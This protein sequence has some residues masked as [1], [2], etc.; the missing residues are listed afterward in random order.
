[1]TVTQPPKVSAR[2][3]D[4]TTLRVGGPAESLTTV[5]STQDLLAAVRAADRAATPVL[6]LGGGSNV[7]VDD[8][9]F[10]GSVLK[11]ATRGHEGQ[12]ETETVL[13]RL[14]AGESWDQVVARTVEDGWSGL[15]ALSGIPGLVGATPIQN[16][17]AYGA[18]LDQALVEVDCLDRSTGDRVTLPAAACGLAY[19][20]SRFKADLG[21][22]V[23]LTITLRLARSRQSAPIRYPQLAHAL[24]VEI[25]AQ[26]DA[27]RVR[28][29]VLELRRG[30]GMVLDDNDHDTWSA[31]S[32]FTNPI[33]APGVADGLPA[34]APRFPQADGR[35]KTS[36]AW[37]IEHAGYDKGYGI[38]PAQLSRKH[39][40]AVT[41]RGGATAADLLRLAREVRAGVG[42]RFGIE[43]APEPVLIR[44]TL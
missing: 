34:S 31:G 30:K 40:L 29:A 38:P 23:I 6:V 15:E 22:Y 32:F 11:V 41:N 33:L 44:C 37:L 5:D 19:R 14:A 7:L 27:R 24:G 13:L 12:R 4:H 21:R 39:T 9:G 8:D 17:G 18:A 10:D 35:I 16:V 3:A 36:A 2:L 26:P 25:G 28:E 20:W 1:M 42:D 43:L